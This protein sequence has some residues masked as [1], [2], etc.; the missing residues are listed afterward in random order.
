MIKKKIMLKLSDRLAILSKKQHH[1]GLSR[2]KEW[3]IT[4][5]QF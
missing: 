4:W 2:S 1:Y 5:N 3:L